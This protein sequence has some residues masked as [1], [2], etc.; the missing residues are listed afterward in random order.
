MIDKLNDAEWKEKIRQ[1][2]MYN[3]YCEFMKIVTYI[4]VFVIGVTVGLI[5]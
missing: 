1:I 3:F 2:K 4:F 5:F